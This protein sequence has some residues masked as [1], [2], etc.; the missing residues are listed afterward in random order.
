MEKWMKIGWKNVFS[1][2]CYKYFGKIMQK[3]WLYYF[4]S[5]INTV[6]KSV[7]LL[8][9]R[10]TSLPKEMSEK[11]CDEKLK[12]MLK[13]VLI[14][15]FFI[16]IF[17]FW[18]IITERPNPIVS[19]IFQPPYFSP[20]PPSCLNHCRTHMLP[21]TQALVETIRPQPHDPTFNNTHISKNVF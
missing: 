17:T 19:W 12:R 18:K 9:K 14:V 8:V 11:T 15:M 2:F 5:L 13:T 10:M 3:I 4:S 21:Q 16:K 6:S 20:T 7:H 1:L